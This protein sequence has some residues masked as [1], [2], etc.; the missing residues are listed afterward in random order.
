MRA[1]P[2][3][4]I[5]RLLFAD[6]ILWLAVARYTTVLGARDRMP[7]L[8]VELVVHRVRPCSG[9]RPIA[10]ERRGRPAAALFVVHPEPRELP[11]DEHRLVAPV[12]DAHVEVLGGVP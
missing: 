8:P 11:V 2:V 10:M 12:A 9:A 6:Q 3:G 5:E 4:G 1:G 7:E